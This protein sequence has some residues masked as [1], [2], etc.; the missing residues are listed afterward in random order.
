M[1]VVSSNDGLLTNVEV[2]EVLIENRLRRDAIDAVKIDLQNR[3]TVESKV[4]LQKYFA[5]NSHNN[6][7]FC[8]NRL[9]ST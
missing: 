8:C 4:I 2:M 3:E 1:E 6:Y 7:F 5:V 9:L